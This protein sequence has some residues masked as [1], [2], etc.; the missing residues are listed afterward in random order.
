[1]FQ[2]SGCFAADERRMVP[3][4]NTKQYA[5]IAGL[6]IGSFLVLNA[7]TSASQVFTG[8]F[9][10]RDWTSFALMMVP[11]L[12]SILV[13]AFIY[14]YSS[15]LHFDEL[16]PSGINL[17]EAGIKL[18]GAYW[19]VKAVLNVILAGFMVVGKAMYASSSTGVDEIMLPFVHGLLYGVAGFYFAHRTRVIKK[20][21][22]VSD[23]T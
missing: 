8:S 4:M 14:R 2:P 7:V 19:I 1:M 11:V 17:L 15:S 13:A 12:L 16:E 21:L 10:T 18:M 5:K 6:A 3:A 20:L 23:G 9:V 22:G